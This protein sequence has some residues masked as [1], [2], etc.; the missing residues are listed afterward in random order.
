MRRPVQ[1][2]TRWQTRR[3]V[4]RRLSLERLL[5]CSREQL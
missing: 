3:H 4:A 2:G 5:G 1:P